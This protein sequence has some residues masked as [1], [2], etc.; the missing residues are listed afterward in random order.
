[1]TVGYPD[2]A[3]L[4]LEGG[5]TL[6]AA[7]GNVTNN[8]TLFK[9]YVGNWPYVNVACSC[10]STSDFLQI[11]MQY[12][13]DSTFTTLV[14]FRNA[15]RFGGQFSLTQYANMSDWLLFFINTKSNNPY[16]FGQLTL[17]ATVGQATPV[18]IP[19]LDVPVFQKA[20]IFTASEVDMDVPGHVSPGNMQLNF[21]TAATDWNLTIRH[22]DYGSNAYLA[23]WQTSQATSPNAFTMNWPQGDYPIRLD[24]TNNDAAS[25]NFQYSLMATP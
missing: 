14:G 18:I 2:Y 5:F 17:F 10:G 16:P 22:Y 4:A 21:F 1:M 25:R 23:D 7:T 24:V 8:T 19:S 13:S 15:I 3:R 20:K 9:G 12:Y 11:A 6:F